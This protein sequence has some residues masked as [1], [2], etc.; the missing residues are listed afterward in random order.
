MNKIMNGHRIAAKDNVDFDEP[1]PITAQQCMTDADY[2][3][4]DCFTI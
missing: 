1:V 3:V 4:Y 2:P